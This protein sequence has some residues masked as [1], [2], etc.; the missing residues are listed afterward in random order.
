MCIKLLKTK[1]LEFNVK[2]GL[3]DSLSTQWYYVCI[4]ICDI[5]IYMYYIE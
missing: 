3:I 1:S 5:Y 2:L 4:Y